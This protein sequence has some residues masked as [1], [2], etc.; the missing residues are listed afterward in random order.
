MA[1]GA[2]RASSSPCTRWM[3]L[4]RAARRRPGATSGASP[5][6]RQSRGCAWRPRPAWR[7]ACSGGR[8]PRCTAGRPA[9]VGPRATQCRA[10]LVEG[11]TPCAVAQLPTLRCQEVPKRS[12]R[13]SFCIEQHTCLAAPAPAPRACCRPARSGA[14]R[15]RSRR[16]SAPATERAAAVRLHDSC[17]SVAAA[18]DGASWAVLGVDGGVSTIA[19]HMPADLDGDAPAPDG[20]LAWRAFPPLTVR[21]RNRA[22]STEMERR[23]SLRHAD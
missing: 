15:R 10:W 1:D 8:A 21:L 3:S 14:R 12:F 13:T 11:G 9:K 18:P 23:G 6:G 22:S 7:R 4:A 16:R 17:C 5:G 19:V 20:A 2:P